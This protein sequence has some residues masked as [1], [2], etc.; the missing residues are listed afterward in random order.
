MVL[1]VPGGSPSYAVPFK[2]T[3]VDSLEARA[4]RRAAEKRSPSA[5]GRAARPTSVD[6]GAGG[7]LTGRATDS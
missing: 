4:V 1:P 7:L 6:R 5:E 2:G 3:A